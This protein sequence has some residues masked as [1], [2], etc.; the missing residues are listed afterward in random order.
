MVQ[1][2]MEFAVRSSPGI[3]YGF[4]TTPAG[5]AQWFADSVDITAD[6][7]TFTWNGSEDFASLIETEEDVSAKYRW[8]WMEDSEFFEFRIGKSEVTGDTI[9]YITDFAEKDEVDDQRL[10]WESQIKKLS[11]SIGAG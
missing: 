1:Y 4:L 5:M 11:R 7:Y 8:D 9:L 6:H 2:E 3:L 10:L